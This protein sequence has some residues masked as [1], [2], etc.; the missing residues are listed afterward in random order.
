[1]LSMFKFLVHIPK[2]LCLKQTKSQVKNLGKGT[3]LKFTL[4]KLK[5]VSV[6]HKS[7]FQEAI[8]VL[9]ENFSNLKFQK[10]HRAKL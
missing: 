4:R 2:V 10:L 6:A 5:T 9:L 1:M 8:L 7:K 3:E